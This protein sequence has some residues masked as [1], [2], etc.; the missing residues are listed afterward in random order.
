MRGFRINIRNGNSFALLNS[1][2]RLPV[3]R[4]ISRRVRSGFLRNLQLV[5][6]FDVGTAW[7]GSDPFSDDN[8]L[9][10]KEFRNGDLLNV[11]VNFFRDPIVAGYG[12]GVRSVLF[13]YFIRVD[14]AWGIETR[15]VLDP[16]LFIALGMDF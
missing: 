6:F 1:E 11:K 16:R 4:Y 8:P 10:T 7:E 14:Y 12:L 2:L 9:N 13:G 5:G 3:V 15:Q